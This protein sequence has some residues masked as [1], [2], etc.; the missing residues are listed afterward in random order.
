MI[1]R[2]SFD[3][4]SLTRDEA[5][6]LCVYHLRVAAALFQI[7]PDDGNVALND[8]IQRQ[9]EGIADINAAKRWAEVML[10]DYEDM[11]RNDT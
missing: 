11:K 6:E 1:K 10:A 3:G 7:V 4:P 5:T 9:C 2:Y 8:E